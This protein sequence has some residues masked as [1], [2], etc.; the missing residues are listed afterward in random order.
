[1]ILGY[2]WKMLE[3]FKWNISIFA[4]GLE[5]ADAALKNH[6]LCSLHLTCL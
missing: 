4:M 6:S 1:M 3:E 2:L 5:D